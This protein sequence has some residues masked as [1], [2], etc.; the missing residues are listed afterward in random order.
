MDPNNPNQ[1]NPGNNNPNQNNP[2]DP[3]QSGQWNQQNP[4]WNQQQ[5]NP[6]WNQQQQNPNWNQQQQNPNWNQQQ[7]WQQQQN[8]QQWQQ[9]QQFQQQPGLPDLPN[10]TTILVLGILSIVFCGIGLVLSIIALSMSGK[11][12]AEY[13][14]NPGRYAENS[15]KNVNTGRICAI[16]GLVLQA[17]GFIIMMIEILAFGYIF[18]GGGW[19]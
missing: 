19:D 17:I 4:Q 7:Q 1:N 8:Q 10:A 12:K 5:Q 9:P 11:A 18:G 15:Y 13:E 2:N 16:I 14:A 3:N 6:Q